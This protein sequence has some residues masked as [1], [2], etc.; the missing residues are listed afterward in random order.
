MCIYTTIHTTYAS[1]HCRKAETS[2]SYCGAVLYR[3]NDG[4]PTPTNPFFK[5]FTD[6]PC[7]TPLTQHDRKE[8]C[9][10]CGAEG[11]KPSNAPSDRYGNHM[12]QENAI[13]DNNHPNSPVNLRGGGGDSLTDVFAERAAR[14]ARDKAAKEAEA[15]R[16]MTA[17]KERAKERARLLDAEVAST[18]TAKL[19][20]AA[21]VR[22][23]K[24]EDKRELERVQRKIEEDK[25]RRRGY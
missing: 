2:I 13:K 12:K 1:C 7:F 11:R 24:L 5:V 21:V 22:K 4:L 9:D 17:S 6:A 3:L 16:E 18:P 23:K 10:V 14:M 8:D 19:S 25:A 20:P 15:L